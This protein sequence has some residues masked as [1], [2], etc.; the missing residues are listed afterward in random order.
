MRI[1]EEQSRRRDLVHL[2]NAG[3]PNGSA[4]V[5]RSVERLRSLSLGAGSDHHAPDLVERM[6]HTFDFKTRGLKGN[7]RGNHVHGAFTTLQEA[8]E[9]LPESVSFDIELSK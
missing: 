1:S 8:L 3:A 6:K 2:A 5:P 4:T 7:T 9:L